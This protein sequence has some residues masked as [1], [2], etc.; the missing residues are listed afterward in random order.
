MSL[1]I[2]TL[3]ALN[4]STLHLRDGKDELLWDI[5]AAGNKIPVQVV[6]FGPGSKEY[7][8]AQAKANARSLERLKKRGKMDLS[9]EEKQV[10]LANHLTEITER[11]ENLDYEG[12]TGRELIHAVYS[13]PTIG[14]IAE[15]VNKHAADWSNFTNDSQ[16]S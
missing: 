8:R 5:D 14:F 1:N 9:A 11:F 13:D 7:Q 6:V 15:Q 16:T 2:K 12:K 4:T 10:E 3:A